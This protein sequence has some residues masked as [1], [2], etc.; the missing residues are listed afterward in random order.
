[1]RKSLDAAS[2]SPF[3]ATSWS[4]CSEG[5]L[6][7]AEHLLGRVQDALAP[8][9]LLQPLEVAVE[10]RVGDARREV[11]RCLEG[12]RLLHELQ[13][14]VVLPVP[15]LPLTSRL[16][17]KARPRTPGLARYPGRLGGVPL[18]PNRAPSPRRAGR[19]LMLVIQFSGPQVS[20]WT[21]L[22]RSCRPRATSDGHAGS[23]PRQARATP[24]PRTGV[25]PRTALCGVEDL[26]A[27]SALRNSS[28][29]G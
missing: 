13:H 5:V 20:Q 29:V 12:Q 9:L 6:H 7:D 26:S 21:C 1:L 10:G 8:L 16:R 4:S 2:I 18:P 25:S 11:H 23:V 27:S 28:S 24:R 15:E 17:A 19:Y 14:E 3:S 22:G